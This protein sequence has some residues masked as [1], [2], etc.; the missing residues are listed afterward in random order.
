MLPARQ[1][2]NIKVEHQN[3]VV[4][5]F[6]H[7]FSRFSSSSYRFLQQQKKKGIDD[8]KKTSRETSSRT[9][10]TQIQ[11]QKNEVR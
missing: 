7:L 1:C 8:Q 5:I 6:S 11:I 3:T 9:I 10:F 2:F 4:V